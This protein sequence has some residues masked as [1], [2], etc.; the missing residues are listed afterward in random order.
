MSLLN[1]PLKNFR[2]VKSSRQPRSQA[3]SP[4][5]PLSLRKELETNLSL[6]SGRDDHDVI[7]IDYNQKG[8]FFYGQ[9]F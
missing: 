1:L 5:P 6:L 4:L 7:V 3:L 8:L 9:M 2:G